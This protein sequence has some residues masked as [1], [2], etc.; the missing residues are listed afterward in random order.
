M[1][2]Y[3]N[4]GK[5]E[6]EVGGAGNGDMQPSSDCICTP[7]IPNIR[8]AQILLCNSYTNDANIKLLRKY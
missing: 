8:A 7:Q 6:E 5:E 3:R 4:T 2:S 1:V